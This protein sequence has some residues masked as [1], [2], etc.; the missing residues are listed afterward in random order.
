MAVA[1]LLSCKKQD[2]PDSIDQ[3]PITNEL[4]QFKDLKNPSPA[5]FAYGEF[6]P[7][8]LT[9]MNTNNVSGCITT[10]HTQSQEFDK[11]SVL[12]PTSDILYVGSL[13]DANTIQTGEY[14][15]IF[16]PADYV[17]KPIT[18]SVS[19]QGSTGLIA[20]TIE[21]TLSAYRTAMQE[22]TNAEINGEQPAAFTFEVRKVRSRKELVMKIGASLNIGTNLFTSTFNFNDSSVTTKNFYLLKIYQKFYSADIDIPT[23]GNLFNKPAN[24]NSDVAPT[25][26]S[27]IDYGRS[28][29]LLIESSYDSSRVYHALKTT[30]DFWKINGGANIS[31]DVK[32]VTDEMTISGTAIGGSSTLAAETING[33]QSFHD[34]VTK[35]GN[36]TPNSRGAIIA[37]RLR[38]A[39]NHGIYNTIISGDY[40]LRDCSGAKTLLYDYYHPSFGHR[41]T[42]DANFRN[43]KQGWFWIVNDPIYVY[44]TQVAGSVPVYIMQSYNGPIFCL[45]TDNTVDLNFWATTGIPDFYAYKVQ[46]E[47]TVPIYQFYHPNKFRDGLFYDRTFNPFANG[48]L[49][50]GIKFYAFE[51]SN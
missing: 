40:Y 17:R 28:A 47:N 22:I 45:T 4:N 29:Y 34:Y 41:Y 5:K 1:I 14:I 32:Q 8:Q 49:Y 44:R 48:W 38:S 18:I 11:L 37:Y 35:S 39:Q 20:K 7:G 21:P 26:V 25:Y 46:A 12:D 9:T 24:Y 43:G 30:F 16:Y 50:N 36:L 51:S 31:N 19:I 27:S 13:F 42:I 23:D 3:N 15:P 2:L 33:L 6:D 10:V